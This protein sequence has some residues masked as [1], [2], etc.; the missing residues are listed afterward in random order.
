MKSLCGERLKI[1]N[2]ERGRGEIARCRIYAF[3]WLFASDEI[4]ARLMSLI[5]NVAPFIS[6]L[7]SVI[8]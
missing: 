8:R 7:R 3:L 5:V 6:L 4:S 2:P 1:S